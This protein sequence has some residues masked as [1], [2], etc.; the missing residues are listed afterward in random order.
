MALIVSNNN[1][2]F[3]YM[4]EHL[5]I[6]TLFTQFRYYTHKRL[7]HPANSKNLKLWWQSAGNQQLNTLSKSL[8][9]LNICV[10]QISLVGTSET[11]REKSFN[12]WLAGLIDGDGSLLISK[13]GY[14]SLEITMDLQ[15]EKLLMFIKQKLG[16]SVKLRA[17][18]K[19]LR[20]RL[21]NKESILNLIN[22]I[23][24]EIR[25][26][27]R[28]EQLK[29][30]C[31]TLNVLYLESQDL[32]LNNS[33]IAG[34]IDSDGCITGNFTRTNPTIS[35][36]IANKYEEN[37]LC[38][39]TLLGGNI[40][41]SKHGYGHYVWSIQSEIDIIEFLQ[42][43]KPIRSHKI[44]RFNL[45]KTFYNLRQLKAHSADNNTPL[46]KAWLNFLKNWQ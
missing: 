33:W 13:Q 38:V 31:K 37:L 30:L 21:H 36:T 27:N 41:F 42:N 14:P 6:T 44:K 39:K 45:I 1:I 25:F 19:A 17:G 43:I 10:R 24:G 35:I 2:A 11:A 26:S 34:I 5:E 7:N 16:G 3:R 8:Q 40:Y 20:Y 28:Q 4:L 23:N 46:H 32:K 22:R 18:I 29:K 9:I 15:D 12:Q